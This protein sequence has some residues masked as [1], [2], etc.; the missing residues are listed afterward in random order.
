[1]QFGDTLQ[2]TFSLCLITPVNLLHSVIENEKQKKNL[3]S[4]YTEPTE[5]VRRR[6]VEAGA[7][8]ILTEGMAPGLSRI[9]EDTHARWEA[10]RM[11]VAVVFVQ[12]IAVVCAG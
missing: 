12:C 3:F 9:G 6:K 2:N 11:E 10:C 7:P 8:C 4:R 1:M 5:K